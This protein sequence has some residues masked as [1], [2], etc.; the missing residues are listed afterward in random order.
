MNNYGD[1]SEVTAEWYSHELLKQAMSEVVLDRFG[2]QKPISPKTE[3]PNAFIQIDKNMCVTDSPNDEILSDIIPIQGEQLAQAR[4]ART[5]K[6]IRNGTSAWYGGEAKSIS[7][8]NHESILKPSMQR[9]VL[10]NLRRHRA[11]KFTKIFSNSMEY[12]KCHIVDSSYIAVT[13]SDME[14]HLERALGEENGGFIKVNNYKKHEPISQYEVGY[15]E[16]VR[17]FCSPYFT[18]FKGAGAVSPTNG[19]RSSGDP[20]RYDVYPI[21]YL[22]MGAYECIPLWEDNVICPTV[23]LPHIPRPD[24]PLGTHGSVGWKMAYEC[25]ILKDERMCRLEVVCPK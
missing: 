7:G 18:P 11:K 4:E 16:G 23:L 14:F 19:F 6:V 1:I 24:Y 21:I 17:Y 5:W 8:I 2:S 13:H 10:S 9:S 20:A 3:W 25:A 15:F 22:G 12:Q